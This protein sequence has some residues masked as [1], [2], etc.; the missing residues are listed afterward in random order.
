MNLESCLYEGVVRHRRRGPI[1]HQFSYKLFML[2]LDLAE[3][4]TL[5]SKR[6]LWSSH[7]ANVAWFRRSDH[8]GSPAESL[9]QTVRQ[10]VK[11][12]LGF[13]PTGPIRLLTHLRYF[14]FVINPISIYYCF[15]TR[16]RVAA[17]VAEV[18]NTPWG[19]RH[20]Y[21][22]SADEVRNGFIRAEMEK[23]LHVSPFLT[24]NYA[25]RFRLNTPGRSLAIKIANVSTVEPH[26]HP[27][28]E[29]TAVLRRRELTGPELARALCRYPFMTVQVAWGIYWQALKL[30]LKGAPYVP[31]PQLGGRDEAVATGFA[32]DSAFS[33]SHFEEQ[34]QEISS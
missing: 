30:R 20:V 22:F 19:E 34:R 9:D 5:F 23:R 15:D 29:A 4:P 16:E 33:S 11:A 18:T 8:F 7:A 13:R 27:V 3:L 12:K 17:I 26:D 24:M 32:T 28:L 2:Y 21:V 14:G 10:L 6:W 1:A 31:H 25:Y